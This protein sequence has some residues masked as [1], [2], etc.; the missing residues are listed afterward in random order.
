[1]VVA[2]HDVALGTVLHAED[3]KL[4]TVPVGLIPRDALHEIEP[5]AGRFSKVDLV[6]GEMVLEH[7]L[8]DPTN[9]SHDM[10]FVIDD[11]QVLMAFQP[12]DLMTGLGILQ[13]GDQ[14]DILV[15]MA[16]AVAAPPEDEEAVVTGDAEGPTETLLFTYDAM[17]RVEI[18]AMIADITYEEQASTTTALP[19][20]PGAEEEPLPEPEVVEV[21]IRA[22]LLALAPQDA[23]VLKHLKDTGAQFDLVLRSPSSEQFFELQPVVPQ[24]LIDLFG[25]ELPPR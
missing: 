9:V 3:L 1:M 11:S 18:S 10:A 13:R 20:I 16:H 7:N 8:A 22:Y 5:I 24:Y 2:T 12:G 15:S 14:V 25:L 19:S 21:R 17:Q 6:T 23:L 4:L